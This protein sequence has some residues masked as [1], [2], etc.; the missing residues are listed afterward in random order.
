MT[1]NGID[2]EIT[3]MSR[4]DDANVCSIPIQMNRGKT[5][6]SEAETGALDY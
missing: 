3:L 6:D 4:N 5:I 1:V 2:S